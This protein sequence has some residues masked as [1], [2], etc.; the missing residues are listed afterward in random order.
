[1][2]KDI[3]R[4][5]DGTTLNVYLNVS[6]YESETKIDRDIFTDD[7][8]SNVSIN[9]EKQGKMILRSYYD[10]GEGTRFVL[11]KPT[12]IE[13]LKAENTATQLA[14][15]EVYELMLREAVF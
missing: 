5:S 8:L 15:V 10:F 6:E 7:N 2:S 13:S 11:G 14:I 9:G 12:E 1:M 4:F 3:I